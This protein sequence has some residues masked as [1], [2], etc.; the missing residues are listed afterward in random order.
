M[1]SLSYVQLYF[2]SVFLEVIAF[3]LTLVK[4]LNIYRKKLQFF[5]N[6]NSDC[7]YSKANILFKN[8]CIPLAWPADEYFGNKKGIFRKTLKICLPGVNLNFIKYLLLARFFFI[9]I[10]TRVTIH[11]RHIKTNF[12]Q[13]ARHLLK[14]D[15]AFK[16]KIFNTFLL[17]NIWLVI[18]VVAAD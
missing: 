10:L 8:V 15:N 11:M 17:A 7:G 3:C 13:T 18:D 6:R 2:G 1:K 9:I 4:P 12:C 16:K 5:F 14:D